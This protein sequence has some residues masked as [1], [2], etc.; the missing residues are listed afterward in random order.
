MWGCVTR[1]LSLPFVAPTQ[2]DCNFES[3]LCMWTQAINDQ[4]NWTRAQGPTGS[5]LTGPTN[6]HT[7]GTSMYY[8]IIFF[9][10][11]CLIA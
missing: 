9:D 11:L 10:I 7:L 5:S 1:V 8:F 6:D 4:F 2:Y 3:G